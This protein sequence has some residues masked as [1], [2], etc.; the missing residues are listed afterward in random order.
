M[1]QYRYQSYP[2]HL[3]DTRASRQQHQQPGASQSHLGVHPHHLD[4]QQR[5]AAVAAMTMPPQRQMHHVHAPIAPRSISRVI[6][7]VACHR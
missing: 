5:A 1:H 7:I 2:V 3:Y 4:E 6:F